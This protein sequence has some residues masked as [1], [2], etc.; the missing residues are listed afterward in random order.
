MEITSHINKST[1]FAEVSKITGYTGKNLPTNEAENEKPFDL[2]AVTADEEDLLSTY[3]NDAV[4]SL[5]DA[6]KR[7][8][9]SISD[10]SS[11][12]TF[13]FELPSNFDNTGVSSIEKT[14]NLYV[15]DWI[16]G[17]WFNVSKKDEVAYYEREGLRLLNNL[18]RLLNA[19]R[20]PTKK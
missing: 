12:R 2:V 14:M 8:G 3:W 7:Y 18:S 16:C 10:T 17:K 19:R 15:V 11:G 4:E 20:K 5:F 1:V 13:T 6:V 9:A